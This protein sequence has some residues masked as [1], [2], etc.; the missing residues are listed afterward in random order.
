[1]KNEGLKKNIS[2][3]I[4]ISVILLSSIAMYSLFRS[5]K[6]P[7]K[8]DLLNILKEKGELGTSTGYASSSGAWCGGADINKDGKVDMSDFDILADNWLKDDC[9][10]ENN[11]CDGADIDKD[12][13]VNMVDYS[14]FADNWLRQDCADGYC[15]DGTLIG[16][17]S[18]LNPPLYCEGEGS[19]DYGSGDS[20]GGS[21]DLIFDL[22]KCGADAGKC[23]ESNKNPA[24]FATYLALNL[25]PSE[26]CSNAHTYFDEATIGGWLDTSFFETQ[27]MAQ[28]S[29]GYP[30]RV[31]CSSNSFVVKSGSGVRYKPTPCIFVPASLSNPQQQVAILDW[32]HKSYAYCSYTNGNSVEAVEVEL[33]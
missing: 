31:K 1:M 25:P 2:L 5:P 26:S 8:Q 24:Q 33:P 18:S 20:G 30:T 17:C 19:G 6:E 11:W 21:G 9:A 7:T 23:C 28:V 3:V 27:G 29:G 22:S 15:E 13:I 16:E 14:I 32:S 10:E 12:G 4:V